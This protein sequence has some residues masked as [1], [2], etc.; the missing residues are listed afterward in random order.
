MR[1]TE[2]AIQGGLCFINEQNH[3]SDNRLGHLRTH[4]RIPRGL[5]CNVIGSDCRLPAEFYA[6]PHIYGPQDGLP[7]IFT[8]HLKRIS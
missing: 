7:A 6:C 2:A 5:L 3:F 4:A 1:K 8:S